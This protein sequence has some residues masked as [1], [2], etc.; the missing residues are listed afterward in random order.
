MTGPELWTSLKNNSLL[1][2]IYFEPVF[3]Q[4]FGWGGGGWGGGGVVNKV[5]YGLCRKMVTISDL[6]CNLI[7]HFYHL[8]FKKKCTKW[9]VASSLQNAILTFSWSLK[10][11]LRGRAKRT[12]SQ[13]KQTRSARKT[14]SCQLYGK[15]SSLWSWCRECQLK[16]QKTFQIE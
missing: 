16:F 15:C 11:K 14:R 9:D 3:M 7:K 1:L 13:R 10:P 2:I 6:S 5:H 4:N 12:R 8:E